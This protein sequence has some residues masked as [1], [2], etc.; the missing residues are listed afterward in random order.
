MLQG[1]AKLAQ[2][3]PYPA[4]QGRHPTALARCSSNHEL[5]HK[6]LAVSRMRWQAAR[7]L[8]AANAA[9]ADSGPGSPESEPDA[10]ED[11]RERAYVRA[12]LLAFFASQNRSLFAGEPP[13]MTSHGAAL[14]ICSVWCLL[15]ASMPPF[16]D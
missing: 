2:V 7:R 4:N 5:S 10:G 1:A 8:A 12:L 15:A 3:L 6:G 16:Q 9:A 11:A 13:A 14:T